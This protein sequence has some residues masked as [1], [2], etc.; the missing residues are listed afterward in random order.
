MGTNSAWN[1]SDDESFIQQYVAGDAT[2]FSELVQKY[3]KPIFNLGLRMLGSTPDA[4]D[5]LQETF[6]RFDQTIR[7]RKSVH[8]VGSW[9][10]TVALNLCRK[11]LR[12]KYAIRYISFGFLGEST[13]GHNQVPTLIPNA[14][15]DLRAEE[16]ANLIGQLAQKL[17]VSLREALVL[18]VFQDLAEDETAEILRISIQTL[19][20]R[21]TRAKDRLWKALQDVSG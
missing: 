12:R 16:M 17:P 18:R 6:L 1:S 3:Q 8:K 11:N 20:V 21:L 13:D 5:V 2:A 9:L 14:E 15:E 19:R 7:A 4:E 10:Y